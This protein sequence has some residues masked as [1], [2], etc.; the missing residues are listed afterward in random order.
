MK[1]ITRITL[2]SLPYNVEIEAKKELE[3]YCSAI[4]KSL[5]ADAEA[6]REIEAR[7]TELLAERGVVGEKVIS[8][9]DV[10]SLREKLGEPEDFSDGRADEARHGAVESDSEDRPPKRLMRDMSNRLLGGVCSG[11]A[12]YLSTD[13]VLIRVITIALLFLTA[14]VVVPIYLLMWLIIPPARTA[15]DRLEMAGKPVTLTAIQQESST[16]MMRSEPALLIFF[17]Y[18]IAGLL[19]LGIVGAAVLMAQY[20]NSGFVRYLSM[21]APWAIAL[22]VV[23]LMSGALFMAMLGLLAYAVIARK[24][25]KK[26][27]IALIIIM[28]SGMSAFAV[29]AFGLRG[30]YGQSMTQMLDQNKTEKTYDAAAFSG[31]TRL[32]VDSPDNELY[33]NYT[34]AGAPSMVLSYDKRNMTNTPKVTVTKSGDTATLTT[35]TQSNGCPGGT[36]MPTSLTIT[37]PVLAAISTTNGN[38]SYNT[39]GQDTLSLVAGGDAHV[40]IYGRKDPVGVVSASIAGEGFVTVSSA[41]VKAL[42][43]VYEG[44]S[45]RALAGNVNTITITAPTVCATVSRLPS[46]MYVSSDT[47]MLNGKSVSPQATLSCFSLEK[48]ED[49]I[50]TSAN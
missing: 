31:V 2:A 25:T 11:I 28:V 40:D 48:D 44:G 7:M 8:A 20:L 13:A 6:M 49:H 43:L 27:G 15:A 14:G 9:Q 42:S 45:G 3:K 26:M 39:N 1:D 30:D 17:R 46:L 12:A 32:V 22:T 33:V 24:F 23:A 34:A 10:A 36:C 5:D 35:D 37:G 29:G 50:L 19:L 41:P 18:S 47:V 16:S 38:V 4:E 21:Q